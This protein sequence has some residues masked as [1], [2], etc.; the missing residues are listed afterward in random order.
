MQPFLR[1]STM[2]INRNHIKNI[3]IWQS[4]YI[5]EMN[6][7]EHSGFFVTFFGTINPINNNITICEKNDPED[8]LKVKKWIDNIDKIDNISKDQNN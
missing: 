5:I 8:Y 4:K 6:S 3:T 7:N 1:L 2:L